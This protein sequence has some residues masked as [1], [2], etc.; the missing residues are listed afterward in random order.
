MKR[1]LRRLANFFSPQKPSSGPD[2][3]QTGSHLRQ[4]GR[5]APAFKAVPVKQAL[6]ER[7]PEVIDFD[8]GTEDVIDDLGPGKN[9]LIRKYVREDTGTHETLTILDDNA[10][11]TEEQFGIDPYN[12]GRFDRSKNWDKRFRKD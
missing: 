10:I 2:L 6:P 9:V 8:S 12:T 11:D 7:Q 1:F 5:H 3:T 4:T